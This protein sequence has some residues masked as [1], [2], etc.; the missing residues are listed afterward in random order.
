MDNLNNSHAAK[1]SVNKEASKPKTEAVAK[2]KIKGG[3]EESK[4]LVKRFVKNDAKSIWSYLF[5]KVLDPTV[6]KLLYDLGT[7][8]I[9]MLLYEGAKKNPTSS[10]ARADQVSYRKYY[11]DPEYTPKSSS[12]S[13]WGFKPVS[14][15]DRDDAENVLKRMQEIADSYMFV[16]AADYYELSG[17]TEFPY[18]CNEYGWK[19][20]DNVEV[21]P[22]DDPDDSNEWIIDLPK[23][24]PRR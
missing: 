23:P 6:R 21:V 1:E 22:N 8:T 20:L 14:Y 5:T 7:N 18:T 15:G 11:D 2:G 9:H 4:S 12:S 13:K 24:R 17:F 16:T 10:T 19:N 3:G